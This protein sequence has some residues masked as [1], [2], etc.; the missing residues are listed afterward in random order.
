[1]AAGRRSVPE[2]AHAGEHHRDAVLV[3]GGDHLVVAHGAARLDHGDGAVVGDDVEAVAEREERVGGDD[4]ARERRGPRCSAFIAA[5]RVESTR[6]IWPAPMP[7]VCPSPQKTIALDFT[8]LAT[9]QANSRSASC[10]GGR[11][12]FGD[13]LAARRRR[14]CRASGVCTSRPPPTRLQSRGGRRRS[15]RAARSRARARSPSA[16]SPPA[17]RRC[18][19]GAISTSRNC[20]DD[21][22]ERSRASTGRLNAMMPPNADVGS[23]RDAPGTPRAASRAIATPHGFVCLTMTHAGSANVFTHSQRRVGVGDVVVRELLAL[24]LPEAARC[25]RPRRLVAVERRLLVRVLAVAQVLHLARL[26]VEPVGERLRG[27]VGRRA[28]SASSAIAASYAAVCANAL[29]GEREARRRGQR[30]PPCLELGEQRR[31][32]RPGRRRCRRA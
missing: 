14:R 4:R 16:R 30:A 8:Y 24:Q 29:R 13:D 26:Q 18:T 2:V 10:A 23:V 31:R 27:A 17:R 11:R 28:P 5:M 9:R 19:P 15:A 20:A 32:S 6:L 7:S 3:G 25:C 21:R 1:M 22:L 12:R